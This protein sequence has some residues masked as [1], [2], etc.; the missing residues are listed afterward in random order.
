[1]MLSLPL[2]Y[3]HYQ[4]ALSVIFPETW[5]WNQTLPC[6]APWHTGIS[7]PHFLQANLQHLWPSSSS[8]GFELFN[9]GRGLQETVCCFAVSQSCSALCNPMYCSMPV[10]PDLDYLPSLLRLMSS[11]S[12]MPSNHFILCCP[13]PAFKSF[14][15]SESFLM[16][17]LFAS[18]G[19][20]IGASASVLPMHIR[21]WFPSGLTRLTSMLSKGLSRIFSST[22]IFSQFFGAQPCL[23]SNFHIHRWLQ[24]K[25]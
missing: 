17:Q 23:W 14:P 6:A 13:S 19:Q 15:A 25:L 16:S 18:D 4:G 24:E 2:F 21:G 11:E 9:Q 10:F 12:M 20:S 8:K 22:T 1:M 3:L 7:V 5:G